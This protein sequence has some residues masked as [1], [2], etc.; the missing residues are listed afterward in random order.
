[1][2]RRVFNTEGLRRLSM[3]ALVLLGMGVLACGV[4][5]ALYDVSLPYT[6]FEVAGVTGVGSIDP[7]GPAVSAGLQIDDQILHIQGSGAL[8]DAYLYPDQ[9]SLRLIVQREGQEMALDVRLMPPPAKVTFNKIGYYLMAL[10]FWGIAM[11][12]L[13]F[14]PRDSVSQLFALLALLGTFGIIVW[15][16]ADIGAFWANLLM[17]AIA[18]AVG[19]IFVHYHTVF[20]RRI[21]FRGKRALLW[22]LYCTSLILLLLST[23]SDLVYLYRQLNELGDGP[24][25]LAAVIKVY[26]SSCFVVGLLLLVR[27]LRG[28]PSETARRQSAL[29]LLGTA[30]A[31][32]PLLVFIL[33]PQVLHIPYVIPSWISLLMLMFLP[34]SY[35]YG[36]YRHSL[37]KLDRIVNRTVVYFFLSV[38]LALMYIGLFL[39][40]RLLV[41][42]TF[43]GPGIAEIASA[44]VLGLSIPFM[45]HR[46]QIVVDHAFYGGWYNFQSFISSLS[47]ALNEALDMETIVDLLTQNVAKTLR[48]KE[49]ALLLLERGGTLR[50][51]GGVGFEGKPC[52]SADG[53]VATWLFKRGTITPHADLCSKL[54]SDPALSAELAPWCDSDA[55]MWVPLAH[56]GKPVGILVLSNK[57]AD[58]F[59][60]REDHYILDTLA[61]QAAVAIARTQLVDRL[62]GQIH[63]IRALARQVIALQERNQQRLAQEL[64]DDTAHELSVV[65]RL[66]EE[67][68]TVHVPKKIIG[69][70]DVI[71]QSLNRLRDLM[72]E[73]RPPNLGDD[74]EQALREYVA[75]VQR[76]RDLPVVLHTNGNGVVVPRDVSAHL[77]RICQESLNNAWRYAQAQHV[78]VTLDLQPGWV[79]L[80]IRDDGD[81]FDVPEHLGFFIDQQHLGLVGMQE[82][83]EE[84]GGS[85]KLES[86]PGRG[87]R[88]SVVAPLSSS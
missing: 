43:S 71:Q 88:I 51:K 16:M 79:R 36:M 30:M 2:V 52:I 80:E 9:E 11:T 24:P 26:F 34:L 17:P 75:S 65:L 48:L 64:H 87:T 18:L 73:L 50:V 6:G 72:F 82:R 81:G 41:P 14:K 33:L 68:V 44:L 31:S 49:I 57:I 86:A 53:A 37:M 59:F 61:H 15:R 29:I 45:R 60:T 66:L 58:E 67:P 7:Q 42:G 19:P 35:L 76:R 22:A 70:R 74:L 46:I 83:A 12:V 23:A 1:M 21:D 39:A 69:A 32:L 4:A 56:Q 55:H 63:E 3:Q 10:T 5:M 25:S 85:F 62:Q 28:S 77:L 47:P 54:S 8:G 27:T 13:V 78:D 20:P 84:I 40:I 38:V